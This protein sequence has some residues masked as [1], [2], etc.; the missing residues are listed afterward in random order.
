MKNVFPSYFQS[1]VLKS[2]KWR[3]CT[4]GDLLPL[5][6][7]RTFRYL[8]T[9]LYCNKSLFESTLF[10]KNHNEKRFLVIFLIF[11]SRL[12]EGSSCRWSLGGHL[13]PHPVI[14][15]T[16]KNSLVSFSSKQSLLLQAVAYTLNERKYVGRG[17]SLHPLRTRFLFL[18]RDWVQ[19]RNKPLARCL[20]SDFTPYV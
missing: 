4:L 1:S 14:K 15:T 11:R 10:K 18:W 5:P 2:Y 9:C 16:N 20:V 17:T 3:N 19:R 12:L 7:K 13:H 6:S 8:S